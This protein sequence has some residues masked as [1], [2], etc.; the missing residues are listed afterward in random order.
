MPPITT[1]EDQISA[2]SSR[3]EAVEV[4][5]ARLEGREPLPGP[6]PAAAPPPAGA[7][8][9]VGAGLAHRRKA[10][11]H[12]S[13]TLLHHPRRRLPAS[14]ADRGRHLAAGD[15]RSRRSALRSWLDG[16]VG[17]RR[18]G[19]R[20]DARVV[21]RRHC[22]RHRLSARSRGR[23]SSSTCSAPG[24]AAA[25]LALVTAGSLFAAAIARLQTWPGS[26]S[27]G[28]M[29]TGLTL[30]VRLG[31]V[32]PYALNFVGLGV[33]DAVDRVPARMEAAALADG[34]AGGF[35]G[36]RGHDASPR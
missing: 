3:L 26:R 9:M 35:R 22:A 7:D 32:V 16:D 8:E 19:R 10:T 2:L 25:A 31:V 1:L 36:V 33:A 4:R 6:A 30:M 20:S 11:H 14:R 17:D 27:L 28:G 15:R 23:R 21:R 34:I 13:R 18:A 5:L 29:F 12:S 24:S